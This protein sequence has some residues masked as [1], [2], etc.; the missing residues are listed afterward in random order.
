MTPP[1]DPT[2]D[3]AESDDATGGP[4]E[5]GDATVTVDARGLRCP[6]P[7]LRL[8]QA[9]AQQPPGTA[10]RLLATDPAAHTDVAAF[11]RMRG[12]LLLGVRVEG[13]HTAYLV[14]GVSATA[15]EA[16]PSGP[17]AADP[18]MPPAA[19]P[20]RPTTPGGA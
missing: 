12:L 4:A 2:V 15:P 18:G 6:L 14:R 9:L 11:V 17:P 5:S 20:A 10:V 19:P 8:A 3:P 7:V 16:A 1:G 13:E